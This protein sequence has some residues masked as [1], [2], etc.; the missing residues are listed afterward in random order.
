MPA[1][2]GGPVPRGRLLCPTMLSLLPNHMP[3]LWVVG[4]C[5]R[6]P[7]LP[8]E[9]A[10]ALSLLRWRSWWTNHLMFQ[11][12]QISARPVARSELRAWRIAGNKSIISLISIVSSGRTE[13]TWL[14][15][16]FR[17]LLWSVYT[18]SLP[19]SYHG[20]V[21]VQPLNVVKKRKGRWVGKKGQI[22]GHFITS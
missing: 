2:A 10:S 22:N 18:L 1:D 12:R 3:R 9:D 14:Y 4:G 17:N 7:E 19:L 21:C 11:A 13:G 15:T 8:R 6:R 5:Y 16:S 20:L